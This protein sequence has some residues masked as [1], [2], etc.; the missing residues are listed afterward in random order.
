MGNSEV[1][2]NCMGSGQVVDQGAKLVNT[3]LETG[4][5]FEGVGWRETV[6]TAA[7]EGKAVHF[8]GLLSDG[9]VHSNLSQLELLIRGAIRAG[10]T[11]IYVHPLLDGRDVPPTSGLLYIER[12]EAF[13]ASL[14][15]EVTA[16]I[17]SG[18]GRMKCVMDRYESDWSIVRR[19]LYH[20]VHGHVEPDQLVSGYRGY[21]RSAREAIEDARARFPEFQDQF[22]P[23]FVIVDEAGAPV[24]R[25][26][27][28]DAVVNFNFRGDRAIEIS[29]A[30]DLPAG[31]AFAHFSRDLPERP[32]PRARY[33][34]ILEYD[35]EAHIPANFLLPP[36]NIKNVMSEFLMAQEVRCYAIAETHKFG[37]CTY[38][39]NGNRAGYIDERF[40][41]YEEV[42]SEPAEMI[43]ARPEMKAREV[44]DKLIGAIRSGAYDYVRVNFANPDMVGHTGSIPAVIKAVRC[45]DE[46]VGRLMGAVEEVGGVLML[47]ADH[48]NAEQMLTNAGA[49]VT[50]HTLNP[51]PFAIFDPAFAGEYAVDTTGVAVPGIANTAATT[52]NL[53]GFE[54]PAF[55]ERS[56]IQF[57]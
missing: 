37:H 50:S 12:L 2:H 15:S 55:Y 30:F 27:D 48:G 51:V 17:A 20:I 10:A 24:G 5:I 6:A 33:A 23:P 49:P 29:R 53:L 41:L 8:F 44:A 25:V 38:F 35:S 34:G 45:L 19:G 46:I 13:L 28:G 54:A 7:A 26:E 14:G 56:L 4:A 36:P 18:G 3:S 16:K 39:F 11:R 40:E 57:H 22:N 47:T 1:G 32:F 9:S 43:E 42:T 52:L 31:E 21:F